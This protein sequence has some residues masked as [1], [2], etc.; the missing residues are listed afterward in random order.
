ML[1]ELEHID[2]QNDRSASSVWK[3]KSLRKFREL[4]GLGYVLANELKDLEEA[5]E[6]VIQAVDSRLPTKTPFQKNTIETFANC[7][8]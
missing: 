8:R 2:G 4:S 1:D 3:S 6:A 7:N 5:R